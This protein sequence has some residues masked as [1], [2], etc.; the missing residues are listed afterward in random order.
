MEGE[1]LR[2]EKVYAKLSNDGYVGGVE[3]QYGYQDRRRKQ[4]RHA[5]GGRLGWNQSEGTGTSAVHCRAKEPRRRK[6]HDDDH[7]Q[8]DVKGEGGFHA[9]IAHCKAKKYQAQSQAGEGHK[10]GCRDSRQTPGRWGNQRLI[11]A[12][13]A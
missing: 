4:P 2:L 8:A 1:F 11:G 7:H 5:T 13:V 12:G 3:Q 10:D 9:F 6:H